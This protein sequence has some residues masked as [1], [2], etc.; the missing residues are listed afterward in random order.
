MCVQKAKAI[1]PTVL[2]TLGLGYFVNGEFRA[3]T[4]MT[5]AITLTLLRLLHHFIGIAVLPAQRTAVSIVRF[6]RGNSYFNERIGPFA[7]LMEKEYSRLHR[8]RLKQQTSLDGVRYV[9]C[10]LQTSIQSHY[11]IF[12]SSIF[13]SLVQVVHYLS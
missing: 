12:S 6:L 8:G 11:Y 10:F 7:D 9:F 4:V 1:L 5:L 3:R 2:L 13:V